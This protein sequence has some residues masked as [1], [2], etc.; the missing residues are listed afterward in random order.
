MLLVNWYRL[1][2]EK[3]HIRTRGCMAEEMFL[4]R[5]IAGR[6]V[7]STSVSPRRGDIAS[8]NYRRSGQRDG[9]LLFLPRRGANT[10]TGQ[11]M[12]LAEIKRTGLDSKS[13]D[14]V[15]NF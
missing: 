8:R 3:T 15:S 11:I 9:A 2:I 5:C 14:P 12:V 7:S 4:A 1:A 6:P 10:R 13:V